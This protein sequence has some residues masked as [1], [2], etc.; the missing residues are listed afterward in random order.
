MVRPGDRLSIGLSR[1]KR[2]VRVV[3]LSE[4]RGR[5]STPPSCTTI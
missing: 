5:A 4:H 1:I 2:I 3:A